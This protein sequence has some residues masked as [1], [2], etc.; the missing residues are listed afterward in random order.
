MLCLIQILN[1]SGDQ[2]KCYYNFKC[3]HPLGMLSAFNNI[4]SNVGYVLLG[5]L[6]F[7]IIWY[8]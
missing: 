2:D 6:F 1:S 8:R 5:G 3:A 4:W 7:T